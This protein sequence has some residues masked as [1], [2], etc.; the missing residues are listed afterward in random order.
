MNEYR[1]VTTGEIK[2]PREIVKMNPNVSLPKVWTDAI[3]TSLGIEPVLITPKPEVTINQVVILKG[4]VKDGLGNWVQSWSIVPRFT[5]YTDEDDVLHTVGDQ[6]EEAKAKE[7]A[8]TLKSRL[9]KGK[10]ECAKRINTVVDLSAQLNLSAAA[11]AGL[12]S[13]EQL[14]A[15]KSGIGWIKAT[16]DVWPTLAADASKDLEDDSEWPTPSDSIV[17]LGLSF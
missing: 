11:A 3:C 17:S 12:L 8:A 5:E 1:V 7:I 6:E 16:R 13:S 4:A 10:T 2:S 9:D 15:Y 14:A